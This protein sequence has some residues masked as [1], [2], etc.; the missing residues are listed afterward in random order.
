MAVA[1]Y[2]RGKA[3]QN[4]IPPS[5]GG[6]Y[7]TG[8]PSRELMANMARVKVP[9]TRLSEKPLSAAGTTGEHRP[10]TASKIQGQPTGFQV[11]TSQATPKDIFDTDVET[12]DDSTTTVASFIREPDGRKHDFQLDPDPPQLTSQDENDLPSNVQYSQGNSRGRSALEERMIM[13]LGSDPE[14]VHEDIIV[15][16]DTHMQGDE[17]Q[18]G[19]EDDFDGDDAQLFDWR[20]N[21]DTNG[22]PLSWQNIEAVLR[23]T[24]APLPVQNL[25]QQIN[26]NP[27]SIPKQSDYESYS[28][29]N[30]YT[31]KATQRHSTGGRLLTRSR[32]GTPNPRG[33]APLD[34]EKFFGTRP[35]PQTSPSRTVILSPQSQHASQPNITK[36]NKP[37]P[38]QSIHDNHDPYS[39][40][41]LFDITDLSALD[42]S[43]SDNSTDNQQTYASLRLSTLSS[44][45]TKRPLDEFPSDY[46]PNILETKTFA[47]LRAES[48][49]YNPAAP[50]LIFQPQ[51][52]PIPLSEKLARLK[53]L[54]DEQRQTFFA[55]LKLTEW[56]ESG[57]WIIEQFSL[58]LQRT[59]EARR[60]RRKVAALFEKEIERRYELVQ[61]EGK[62]IG[63]RLEEMR[64]GGMDVLKVRVS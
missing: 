59:K 56:E 22:E 64:M 21:N 27:R 25:Q 16:R 46:P 30:M 8:N 20:N 44:L 14:Y 17:A 3:L 24:K 18:T 62:G 57:D 41:G 52:P 33:G 26:I 45:S 58:L 35:I 37:N 12:V 63:Q 61:V 7:V 32:F 13:E 10:V 50:Q 34:G 23:D 54:T 48:F 38:L 39:H 15:P 53:V 47:D 28:D 11:P 5:Q 19:D 1:E 60:E 42:S 36:P 31:P 2:V 49:D 43:S 29:S 4:D 40:G 51:D 9:T 55:S 6:K